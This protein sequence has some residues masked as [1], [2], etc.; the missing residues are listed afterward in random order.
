MNDSC[1][2]IVINPG[3]SIFPKT[4][5]SKTL[6]KSSKKLFCC[7]TYTIFWFRF[8]S[9]KKSFFT[10]QNE[11][12]LLPLSHRWWEY[13]IF[14]NPHKHSA[15]RI[16]ATVADDQVKKSRFVTGFSDLQSAPV[17]TTNQPKN[18]NNKIK[19]TK[20]ND[21]QNNGQIAD[22]GK[23]TT[24][25]IGLNTL[26]YSCALNSFTLSDSLRCCERSFFFCFLRSV[27][28]SSVAG[29]VA[30]AVVVVVWSIY[31]SVFYQGKNHKREN[32][33]R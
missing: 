7:S 18:N 14:T 13:P 27:S 31:Y 20:W 4:H 28:T 12:L 33:K 21:K 29:A 3:N 1:Y 8:D 16:T 17:A 32:W 11:I 24:K 10:R 2:V 30:G 22:E 26:P 15:H 19:L 5:L 9:K 6:K 25:E 23:T